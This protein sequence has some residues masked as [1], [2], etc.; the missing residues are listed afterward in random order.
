MSK[1]SSGI[2]GRTSPGGGKGTGTTTGSTTSAIGNG[3]KS[4]A[5]RP[6]GG[7]F[8]GG[9][10]GGRGGGCGGGRGGREL[11]VSEEL[12][13]A[14][15]FFGGVRF[16]TDGGGNFEMVL[17]LELGPD[18]GAAGSTANG[19]TGT[20]TTGGGANGGAIG[21]PAAGGAGKMTA[22][23]GAAGPGISGGNGAA[24]PSSSMPGNP[25]GLHGEAVHGIGEGIPLSPRS[26]SPGSALAGPARDSWSSTAVY[27]KYIKKLLSCHGACEARVSA[28]D[29]FTSFTTYDER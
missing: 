8:G 22:G 6:E 11:D 27:E 20:V 28:R 7:G 21:S 13:A 17:E 16:G 1:D 14:L 9:R 25:K 19:G 4:G 24:A 29:G 18:G 26:T 15:E 10:G 12:G 5:G 2:G 3:N 23:G